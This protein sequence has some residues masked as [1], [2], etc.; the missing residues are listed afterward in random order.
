MINNF[1]SVSGLRNE[2]LKYILDTGSA[3]MST[4]CVAVAT[5]KSEILSISADGVQFRHAVVN[6][7][8]I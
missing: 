7:L 5:M 8:R 6:Y 4:V 3:N 2:G 1:K